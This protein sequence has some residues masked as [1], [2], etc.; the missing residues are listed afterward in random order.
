MQ[1]R[2]ETKIKQ[3]LGIR[4]FSKKSRVDLRPALKK[5]RSNIINSHNCALVK[6]KFFFGFY[7]NM[8]K[9]SCSLIYSDRGI[10]K[11]TYGEK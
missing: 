9:H 8:K 4:E 5:S 7:I 2:G 10:Q 3:P 11:G 1:L 6:L